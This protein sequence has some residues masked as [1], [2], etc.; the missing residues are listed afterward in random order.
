MALQRLGGKALAPGDTLDRN[1][2][3]RPLIWVERPSKLKRDNGKLIKVQIPYTRMTTFIDAIDD[4]A[5]LHK[6]GK[7]MALVGATLMDPTELAKVEFL[8]PEEPD[9]KKV[10]DRL[11][12][13]ALT[14]AGAHKKR[15]R[16]TLL[17]KLSEYVDRD[18]ELPD[19][20]LVEGEW[21]D[22]TDVDR[23]DMDAYRTATRGAGL[24]LK[25]HIEKPVVQDELKIAGTP[26]RIGFYEGLD[27]DGLPA[28]H[29]IADLKT[30]RYDFGAL[31]MAMQFAGYSRSKFYDN[32]TGERSE[33][34][35]D[36][37]LRW[38][39]MLNLRPGSATVEI[40]WTDIALGWEALMLAKDV[41]AMRNRGRKVFRPFGSLDATCATVDDG[42]NED[43][44]DEGEE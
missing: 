31:K 43:E 21:V 14:V 6:Y 18:E 16:G 24:F 10:L 42:T 17:H 39:V 34:P 37:N 15:D 1:G 35:A 44:E 13:K 22:V 28:G 36:L 5:M 27:P 32:D 38:A 41:R 40:Q 4:K 30:G 9:D 3:G 19:R 2:Q 23:V 7:R 25:G 8:D 12:E 29:L 11:A 26:D 20:V 33:L